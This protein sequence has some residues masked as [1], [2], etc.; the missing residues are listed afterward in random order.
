MLMLVE[1]E[2]LAKTYRQYQRKTQ[3]F[4]EGLI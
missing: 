3:Q 2:A 1:T 4:Q